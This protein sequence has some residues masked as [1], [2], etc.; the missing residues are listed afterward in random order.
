MLPPHT[1]NK[2]EN[3][4]YDFFQILKTKNAILPKFFIFSPVTGFGQRAFC[5]SRFDKGQRVLE[6]VQCQWLTRADADISRVPRTDKS[7]AGVPWTNKAPAGI[8][9]S[10]GQAARIPR[11]DK[12]HPRL[13]RGGQIDEE[14][15]GWG[16]WCQ[17]RRNGE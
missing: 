13:P 8:S 11:L 1:R 6:R 7:T 5:L 3:Y 9:C 16:G 10:A 15:D 17:D 12:W 4:I 14:G 2:I